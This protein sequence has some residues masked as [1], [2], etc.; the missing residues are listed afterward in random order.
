MYS[1][2]H[3]QGKTERKRAEIRQQ[4]SW[5]FVVSYT[6]TKREVVQWRT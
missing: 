4:I 6:L 2:W 1:Y 3:L 5:F